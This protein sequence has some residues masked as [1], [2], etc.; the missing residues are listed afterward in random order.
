MVDILG[1]LDEALKVVGDGK[2]T[3]LDITSNSRKEG[4]RI[5]RQ[6]IQYLLKE[7]GGYTLNEIA[8]ITGVNSHSTVHHGCS[9]VKGEIDFYKD[10]G[11]CL[12]RCEKY[13]ELKGA[14]LSVTKTI[15][16][17]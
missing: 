17:K 1:K 15:K 7:M 13:L 3:M 10:K 6:C 4:V 5:L 9:M 14:Y 12:N 2:Y 16:K 8:F 11:K